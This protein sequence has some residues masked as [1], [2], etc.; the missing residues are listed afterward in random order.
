MTKKCINC[1]TTFKTYDKKQKFCSREC[2]HSYPR[3]KGKDSKKFSMI[4]VKCDYCGKSTLKHPSA[5]KRTKHSVC[6]TECRQLLIAKLKKDSTEKVIKFCIV[7]NKKIVRTKSHF[8]NRP[9]TNCTCSTECKDIFL[10][11][12]RGGFT[13]FE[14]ECLYCKNNF[15]IKSR[16]HRKRK[17][18]SKECQQKAFPKGKNHKNYKPELDRD[19]RSRHR[20][21]YEI[22]DWRTAV[23]K[24]DNYTCQACK[25]KGDKLQAHHI[26]NYSSHENLR[27]D[28]NNGITFCTKCHKKF[29]SIYGIVRNNRQQIEEFLYSYR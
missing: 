14:K 13:P 4:E 21:F 27:T 16:G 22:S 20:L 11:Q 28:I 7:C 8:K 26:L 17:Y 10:K 25:K 29:H 9:C 2:Y 6:S 1:N 19:Y 24:R 18:C 3:A 5:L 15:M 23:F 12:G